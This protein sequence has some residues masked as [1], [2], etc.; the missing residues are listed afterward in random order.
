MLISSWDSKATPCYLIFTYSRRLYHTYY[1]MTIR[2]CLVSFGIQV[3]MAIKLDDQLVVFSS[4]K[5]RLIVITIINHLHFKRVE[6]PYFY[7]LNY[8][9]IYGQQFD[10]LPACCTTL[11]LLI[12]T[13]PLQ[14]FEP[15][16]FQRA[17]HSSSK[18]ECDRANMRKL[19]YLMNILTQLE[20]L[21]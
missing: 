21:R 16:F 20:G 4:V 2:H 17:Q 13:M 11:Q 3:Q 12:L 9:Q 10:Y 6:Q 5:H 19:N 8:A 7:L 14:A 15:H 1:A 18:L